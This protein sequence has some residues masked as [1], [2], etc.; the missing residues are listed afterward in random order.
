MKRKTVSFILVEYHSIEEIQFFFNSLD[1]CVNVDIEVI[2]SSNSQYS[3]SEQIRLSKTFDNAMWIFNPK[4]GGFAYAMNRGLEIANGDFLIIANPD[5]RIISGF[6]E[7]I[8]FFNNNEQIGAIAPK[9]INVEGILQDSFRNYISIGNFIS[10]FFKRIITGKQ[11]VLDKSYFLD[12]IQTVD[13]LIGAFIMIRKEVYL[14]VGGLDENYFLYCEDMDW[15][16]SIR[17]KGYE[18]V[19]YPEAVINYEGT[20]SARKS[21][22]YQRIFLKSLFRYWRKFGFINQYKRKNINFENSSK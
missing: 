8:S 16:T 12:K 18:I 3:Q 13:W 11:V 2:I 19:Y 20:R 10:R 14:Q 4:N 1:V 17:A 5:V 6:D 9:I 7:I 21:F 15:C 22:K